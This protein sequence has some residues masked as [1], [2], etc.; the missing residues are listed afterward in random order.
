MFTFTNYYW[1]CHVNVRI[2]AKLKGKTATNF[3]CM[4][5]IGIQG[6]LYF[7]VQISQKIKHKK[8]DEFYFM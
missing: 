5:T 2:V 6:F 1:Y 7:L 4:Y 3:F 8:T